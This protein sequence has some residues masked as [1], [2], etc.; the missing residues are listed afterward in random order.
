MLNLA[1]VK[2]EPTPNITIFSNGGLFNADEIK[3]E[4]LEAGITVFFM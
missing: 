3:G 2:A 1:K 4:E